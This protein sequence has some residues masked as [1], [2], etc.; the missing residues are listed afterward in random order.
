MGLFGKNT[1]TVDVPVEE[2]T[3]QPV[4][5]LC[6]DC[7]K[8]KTWTG[9]TPLCAGCRYALLLASQPKPSPQGQDCAIC[10]VTEAAEWA[11]GAVQQHKQVRQAH[12]GQVL[13]T[14]SSSSKTMAMCRDCKELIDFI[15][16]PM[17]RELEEG[18]LDA[19]IGQLLGVTGTVPPEPSYVHVGGAPS[20]HGHRGGGSI[21]VFYGV[22][23]NVT[24]CG[25]NQRPL[26][27]WEVEGFS[28]PGVVREP[29]WWIM[30]SVFSYRTA[31]E[32]VDQYHSVKRIP[33]S[34]QGSNIAQLSGELARNPQ[35]TVL[36]NRGL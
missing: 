5:R 2:P 3:P 29:L 18:V 17:G 23:R 1:P 31:R 10:G 9:P 27:A 14:P 13:S 8:W 32:Y 26:S 19:R 24:R 6:E 21:K 28:T 11:T 4:A 30:R 15:P 20:H 16:A 34:H 7:G 35:R 25:P 33:Q 22:A 36:S 12:T